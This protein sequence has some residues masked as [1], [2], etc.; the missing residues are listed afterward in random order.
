MIWNRSE[1]LALAS[2]HCVKCSGLGLTYSSRSKED[3]TPCL[4]VFRAIFRACYEK[5]K[6]CV[7]GTGD[8]RSVNWERVGQG[9]RRAVTYSRKQEEYKADFCLI[10]KRVLDPDEWQIFNLHFLLGADWKLCCS[11]LKLD[12]GNFFHAVYRI[13]RKLGKVFRE[14]EPYALYPLDEYFSDTIRGNSPNLLPVALPTPVRAPLRPY[15]LDDS[16]PV[17]A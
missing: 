3:G 12:R 1:T 16:F 10:S 7:R 14:L 6:T 9:T 4:C 8:I 17:A 15:D 2:P 11:K 5:F 13:E